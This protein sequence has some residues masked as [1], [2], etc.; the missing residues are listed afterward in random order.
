MTISSP[1]TLPVVP[2]PRAIEFRPISVVGMTASPFTGAQEVQAHQGEWWELRLDYS[3][4]VSRELAENLIATFV[5]LNFRE[6]TLRVRAY[7]RTPRGTW[8]DGFVNGAGQTG[9]TLAITG[10]GANATAKRGDFLQQGSQLHKVTA[11]ATLNGSGAGTIDIWPAIRSAPSH[12]SGVTVTNP[13]GLYRLKEPFTWSL[14][15]AMVYGFSISL[16]EA[17]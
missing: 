6:H 10:A 2:P 7:P 16:M 8:T 14:E 1:V 11:D 4:F 5:S 17:F 13:A 3:P 9:K 12:G 15:V